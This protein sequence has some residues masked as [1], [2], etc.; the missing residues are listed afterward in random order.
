MRVGLAVSILLVGLPL[1][2]AAPVRAED[3][4]DA[5]LN[6][7]VKLDDGKKKEWDGSYPE[8]QARP[9][10]QSRQH[11]SGPNDLAE[12]DED[13]DAVNVNVKQVE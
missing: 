8:I 9:E 11:V 13:S 7:N 5:A 2:V 4:K 1:M 6:F 3:K 10:V 12:S